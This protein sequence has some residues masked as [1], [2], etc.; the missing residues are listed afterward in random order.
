MARE[1]INDT[2]CKIQQKFKFQRFLLGY[3]TYDHFICTIEN[4]HIMCMCMLMYAQ[5]HT[6]KGSERKW[7]GEEGGVGD[8]EWGGDV[9]CNRVSKIYN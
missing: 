1:F 7:G 6:R 2:L 5:K 9:M 8:L 4:S 3:D